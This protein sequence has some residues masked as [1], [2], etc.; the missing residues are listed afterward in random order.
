MWLDCNGVFVLPPLLLGKA[1]L[2]LL[3]PQFALLSR[4]P[5]C[6]LAVQTN[7]LLRLHPHI[8]LPTRPCC[9]RSPRFPQRFNQLIHERPF[10]KEDWLSFIN[11]PWVVS[12]WTGAGWGVPHGICGWLADLEALLLDFQHYGNPLRFAPLETPAARHLILLDSFTP[13]HSHLTCIRCTIDPFA[14]PHLPFSLLL[15]LLP[16]AAW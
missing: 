1:Q 14:L 16:S 8:T 3:I 2:W 15:P 6:L 10:L 11:R 12:A 13:S 7:S 5:A 9:L 4:C